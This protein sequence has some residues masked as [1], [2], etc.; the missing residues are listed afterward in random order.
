MMKFVGKNRFYDKD[1]Q[2]I[3]FQLKIKE[4][5]IVKNIL[6]K[7]YQGSQGTV[8]I[9]HIQGQNLNYT[10]SSLLSDK[11]ICHLI[12]LNL[13]INDYTF[14]GDKLAS[15]LKLNPNK[16]SNYCKECG[17]SVVASKKVNGEQTIKVKLNVPLKF[18]E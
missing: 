8:N 10:K 12:V 14:E 4:V 1:P 15:I 5:S 11:Y 17:C 6:S 7:F 18:P 16:F 3:A 13:V 2:S 9:Y